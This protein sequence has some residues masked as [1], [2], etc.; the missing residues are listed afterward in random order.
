MHARVSGDKGLRRYSTDDFQPVIVNAGL[1]R[2]ALNSRARTIFSAA[3][4]CAKG[5]S[6]ELF[7]RHDNLVQIVG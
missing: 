6:I 4:F 3:N 2:D 5:S 1:Q 7:F